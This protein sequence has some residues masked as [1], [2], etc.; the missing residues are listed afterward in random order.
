LR[1]AL[2]IGGGGQ[3]GR[4]VAQRLLGDGWSVRIAGRGRRPAP[5]LDGATFV[6]LD[7]EDDAALARAVGGGVD[8]V[9][10]CVAYTAEHGRQWL[11]LQGDVGALVVVS[12]ASVYADAQG[13]SL[14]EARATGF[15]DF[16]HP[17]K[18]TQAPSRPVRRR[19]PP[20]RS[21][22]SAR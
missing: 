20:T 2:I 9:V 10:D 12:S 18:E 7:R 21:R 22:S 15:P 6:E 14:D 13:R 16:P 1:T 19:T 17:I 11:A 3:I 5:A 8:A 4:A